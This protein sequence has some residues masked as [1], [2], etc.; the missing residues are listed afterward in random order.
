M[1]VLYPNLVFSW[2]VVRG[3]RLDSVLEILGRSRL[4]DATA[5]EALQLRLTSET[6]HSSSF[7]GTSFQA[8]TFSGGA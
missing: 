1:D 5:E 8:L 4:L 2:P 6:A 7:M 3:T